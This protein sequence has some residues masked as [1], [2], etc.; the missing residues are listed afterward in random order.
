MPDVSVIVPVYNAGPYLRECLESI[1]A[2]TLASI[3]VICVDD[4][5]SDG[6]LDV[7]RE[8]EQL[9][10]RFKVLQ[11][12]NAGAGAARNAGLGI[13]QGDYLAFLDADDF[14]EPTMLETVHRRCV[15]D[16]ADVAVFRGRNFDTTTGQHSPAEWLLKMD[17]LPES[18][19]FS[20]SENPEHIIDF[21]TPVAWNKIFNADFITGRGIRFQEIGRANDLLFTRLAMV[22]A[23]RVTIVDEVLVNYRVGSTSNLQATIHEAP[24]EFYEALMALKHAL[25]ESGEFAAVERSFVNDALAHCIYNLNS[26]QTP[27]SFCALYERLRVECFAELGILSRDREYFFV[28]RQYDQMMRIVGLSVESYLFENAR[29]A[30][31]QLKRVRE[32][33]DSANAALGLANASLK[34]LRGSRSHR[35][36]RFARALL[37]WRR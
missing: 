14:F 6:S 36:A 18:I 10:E 7:L 26:L 19:P 5:S 30:R 23:R 4:E 3:E 31:A 28:E 11:Q 13:A 24:L 15:D 20:P 16:D 8:Y 21:T 32:K 27:D 35:L 29:A 34:K 22:R 9:D 12:K 1:R 33:Y 17:R 37:P 25:V 2:Q